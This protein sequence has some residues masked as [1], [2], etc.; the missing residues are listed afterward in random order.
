MQYNYK[1]CLSVHGSSNQPLCSLM[2]LLYI[3]N[4]KNKCKVGLKE[5]ALKA[6]CEI[7]LK[8]VRTSASVKPLLFL[9]K[10]HR[11]QLLQ[12]HQNYTS[13]VKLCS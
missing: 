9:I 3:V 13:I 6:L 1:P 10:V 8:K 4:N 2:Y 12:G 7:L 5:Y 11:W